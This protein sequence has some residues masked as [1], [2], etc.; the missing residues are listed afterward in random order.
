MVMV[1][2]EIGVVFR[3]NFHFIIYNIT[4]EAHELQRFSICAC[5]FISKSEIGAIKSGDRQTNLP[6]LMTQN[7]LISIWAIKLKCLKFNVVPWRVFKTTTLQ[8]IALQI[9][10][11]DWLVFQLQTQGKINTSKV[12]NI[13]TVLLDLFWS[14]SFF[15]YWITDNVIMPVLCDSSEYGRSDYWPG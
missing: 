6:T 13:C 14:H 11:Q 2:L 8:S 10:S 4:Q 9:N 5:G 7:N 3:K 12:K 1:G 15:Y